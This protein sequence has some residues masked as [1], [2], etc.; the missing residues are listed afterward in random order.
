M[1]TPRFL[2]M[3]TIALT[4]IVMLAQAHSQPDVRRAEIVSP[5]VYHAVNCA[6]PLANVDSACPFI[7]KF[8]TSVVRW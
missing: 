2:A 6:T 1:L 8:N 5:A 7:G 4:V 3:P